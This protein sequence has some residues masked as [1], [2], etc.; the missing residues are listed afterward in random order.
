VQSSKTPTGR[1]RIELM[2]PELRQIIDAAC[3]AAPASVTTTLISSS[4]PVLAM[5]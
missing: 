3:A 4:L 1:E 5:T 2:P